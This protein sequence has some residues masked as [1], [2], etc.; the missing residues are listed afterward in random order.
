MG[1]HFA[2]GYDPQGRVILSGRKVDSMYRIECSL[3]TAIAARVNCSAA[4]SASLWHCRSGHV[5]QGSLKKTI[6]TGS[7]L[8]HDQSNSIADSCSRQFHVL[9]LAVCCTVKIQASP[10]YIHN[11]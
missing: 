11:V 7:V 4:S 10:R 6:R 5:G 1:P 9:V 8:E 3:P 2:E